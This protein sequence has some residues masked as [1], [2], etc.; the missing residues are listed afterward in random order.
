MLRLALLLL[1]SMPLLAQAPAPP[2]AVPLLPPALGSVPMSGT[3]VESKGAAA[4]E[5]D[6]AHAAV[7]REDG[8]LSAESASYGSLAVRAMRMSDATGAFAAFTAY[9]HALPAAL[10]RPEHLGQEGASAG[11]QYVFWSGTAVVLGDAAEAGTQASHLLQLLATALPPAHGPAAIPPPLP[12][13]LPTKDLLRP[14]IAYAEGPAGYAAI[15]P[16][17]LPEEAIDFGRD[18][19]VVLAQYRAHGAE[20][21]LVTL[22]SY[23]TPQLAGVHERALQQLLGSGGTSL[24]LG[25]PAVVLRRA[26]PMLVLTSGGFTAAEAKAVALAVQDQGTVT[27]NHPEGYVPE[28]AKAAR[29]LL[30]IAYLTGV[31]AVAAVLLALFLGG[32]RVLLRRLQGKPASSVSD[33]EFITLHID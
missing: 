30:G 20:A 4:A 15:G 14:T 11:K 2:P 21:G 27:I 7:L 17:P 1:A 8:I 28:V 22:L 19:E 32:G 12:G 25:D 24:R 5:V 10:L 18:A 3:P 23:P 9:R 16:A 33:D 6:P 26:G 13:Y 29:L 31:L